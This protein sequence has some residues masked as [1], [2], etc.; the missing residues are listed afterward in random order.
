MVSE[1]TAKLFEYPKKLR[2]FILVTRERLY[3]D[4]LIWHT[5]GAIT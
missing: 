5:C 2:F 4:P 3:I 1:V